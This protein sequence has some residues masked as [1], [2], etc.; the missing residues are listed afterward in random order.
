[1]FADESLHEGDA[2][3]VIDD[4]EFY[5][6]A[7]DVFLGA[8]EGFVFTDDNVRDAV[9]E[10]SAATHGAWR[11]GGI[12]DTFAI[13]AC[14]ETTGVFETVHLGV[15]DHTALLLALVVA[16]T[17]DVSVVDEDRTYGDAA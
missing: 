13:D 5:A 14:G 4:L 8:L 2:F 6:L 17:D 16:A 3:G 10:R 7:A 11:Q 1:M 12:E 9:E 15:M